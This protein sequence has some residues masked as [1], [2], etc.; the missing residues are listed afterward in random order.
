MKKNWKYS[1][2]LIVAVFALTMGIF[3]LFYRFDNKYTARGDQAIQG[4]LY[5]PDDDSV[6]EYGGMDLGDKN[7]SPFGSGTYRMT[8]VLPEKEKQ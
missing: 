3:F 2:L 5:V 6:G 4:I 8:L 1:L 7:K